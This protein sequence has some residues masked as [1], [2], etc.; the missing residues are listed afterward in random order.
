MKG[1]AGSWGCAMALIVLVLALL[2]LVLRLLG[3]A[4]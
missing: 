3:V 1:A 4:V 2:W